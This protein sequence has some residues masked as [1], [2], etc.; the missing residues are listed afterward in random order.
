MKKLREIYLVITPEGEYDMYHETVERAFYDKGRAEKYAKKLDE[1]H[2]MKTHIDEELW[3]RV[4]N[5]AQDYIDSHDDFYTDWMDVATNDR[6]KV[7]EDN[8]RKHQ[9]LVLDLLNREDQSRKY[10]MDDVD[11]QSEI[12]DYSYRNIHS[13]E[14]KT[15]L[16]DETIEGD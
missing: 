14:I 8:F 7:A 9:K 12:E 1:R 4:G 3:E 11:L 13:C 15:I 2:S 6:R 16:L 5:L 10:T